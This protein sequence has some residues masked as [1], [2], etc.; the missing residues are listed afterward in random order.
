MSYGRRGLRG[1]V[2]SSL[3]PEGLLRLLGRLLSVAVLALCF[4]APVSAQVTSPE[5][6]ALLDAGRAAFDAGRHDAALAR[7]REAYELQHDAAILFD[8]G[9][10]AEALHRVGEARR[11]YEQYLRELP[12]GEHRADIEARLS[13][14]REEG[15]VIEAARHGEPG[16]GRVHVVT[17]SEGLELLERV[18]RSTMTLSND[19][20]SVRLDVHEFAGVCALPCDAPL[21]SLGGVLGVSHDGGS[22]IP[23]GHVRGVLND[24]DTL[25]V[26]YDDREGLRI[27]GWLTTILGGIAGAAIT[28][29]GLNLSTPDRLGVPQ[30]PWEM[31]GVGVGVFVVSLAVGFPLAFLNDSASVEVE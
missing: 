21:S 31:I 3:A 25:R 13:A 17:E 9:R 8:V 4:A 16:E 23:A 11:S 2:Q 6:Q 15:G 5:A 29:A 19:V 7:F 30:Y 28:I 12:D 18:S 10:A 14:L 24:G 1:T 20:R 26:H 22:P 27:A